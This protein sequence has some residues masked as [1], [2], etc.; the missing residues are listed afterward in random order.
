MVKLTRN[1]TAKPVLHRLSKK[2][3]SPCR[4]PPSLLSGEHEDTTQNDDSEVY[5]VLC[6]KTIF[7]IS[8][9]RTSNQVSRGAISCIFAEGC[10]NLKLAFS[11]RYHIAR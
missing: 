8:F 10:F 2:E 3:S 5:T 11:Y 4:F 6:C 1:E 7:Y 9:K